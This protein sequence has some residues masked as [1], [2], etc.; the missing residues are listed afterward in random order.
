MSPT[1]KLAFV[2][3]LVW[4]ITMGVLVPT[5]VV[6][7]L[8]GKVLGWTAGIIGGGLGYLVHRYAWSE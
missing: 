6:G 4:T 2:A 8:F 5:A 3:T 7:I 1:S